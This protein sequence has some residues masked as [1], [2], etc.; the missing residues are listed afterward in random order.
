MAIIYEKSPKH[1]ILIHI[2]IYHKFDRNGGIKM[3]KIICSFLI[4][5]E[6]PEIRLKKELNISTT[7]I[8]IFGNLYSESLILSTGRHYELYC[9]PKQSS[10]WSSRRTMHTT[11]G[12]Y[13]FLLNKVKSPAVSGSIGE[14]IIIPSL[15]SCMG[16][17]GNE[18]GFQRLKS[19]SKTPDFL[20]Q[21]MPQFETL[22]NLAPGSV[23]S[24][25]KELPLEVKTKINS[26]KGYPK[27]AYTQLKTFWDE[28]K[29]DSP[30]RD[31]FGII[32]RV[33]IYTSHIAIRFYLYYK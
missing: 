26:D 19:R 29:S 7:Q 6:N 13:S 30:I 11:I 21:T 16:I 10:I 9:R 31:G 2:Y 15:V 12:S 22:W 17:A 8:G 23:M 1:E 18:F 4:P 24:F 20:I 27:T 28:C 25:P 33:N 14:A 32:A 5:N 3:P